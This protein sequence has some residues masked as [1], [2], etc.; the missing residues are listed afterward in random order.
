MIYLRSQNGKV[1]M[2][3]N[4]PLVIGHEYIKC[5][6]HMLGEYRDCSEAQ[7]VL[8]LISLFARD[9]ESCDDTFHF[10]EKGF[11]QTKKYIG[12]SHEYLTKVLAERMVKD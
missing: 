1:L 3:Y 5:Q 9:I 4:A 12:G 2:P 7:K 10:P 11:M 8:T 6:G